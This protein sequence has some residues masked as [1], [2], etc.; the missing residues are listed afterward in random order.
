MEATWHLIQY[1]ADL[2]KKEP[3]NIGVITEVADSWAIKLFA[4]DDQG[5]VNGR[6]LRRFQLS[7]DGYRNWV[8]YYRRL[9]LAGALDTVAHNQ[10]RRPTEFSLV[11]GGYINT[12]Q[13]AED[14]AQRLYGE[15]VSDEGTQSEPRAKVLL[16]SVET[17]LSIAGIS[18][19]PDVSVPASWGGGVAGKDDDVSFDYSFDN[20]QAHLMDRLQLH[21][22]SV[23][24]A[25]MVARDFNARVS[26]VRA[27]NAGK[28]FV[29]FYSGEAVEDMGTDAILTPIFKVAHMI[30]VDEIE[31]A[32]STLQEIIGV[33][34]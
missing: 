6:V 17:T 23:S 1:T 24:T 13:S 7:K 22:P 14:L 18:P 15:L 33:T 25:Q 11:Q 12:Y 2:R 19:I 8:D 3:R 30:D 9:I 28:S 26:A 31:T 4:V 10:S 5:E 32:A 27:A 29:A 16:R 21:Q 34:A 20:G